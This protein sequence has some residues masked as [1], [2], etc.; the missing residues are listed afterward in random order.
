MIAGIIFLYIML[1]N[2]L[3]LHQYYLIKKTNDYERIPHL[4]R[5]Y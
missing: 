4:Q 2:N 5:M 1:L 3:I